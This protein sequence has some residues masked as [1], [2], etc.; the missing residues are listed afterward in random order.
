MHLSNLHPLHS[1]PFPFIPSSLIQKL[2]HLVPEQVVAGIL[3]APSPSFLSL[4]C[5]LLVLLIAF[6]PCLPVSLFPSCSCFHTKEHLNNQVLPSLS[7]SHSHWSDAPTALT[8]LYLLPSHLS[9][10]YPKLLA[11]HTASMLPFFT[12]LRYCTGC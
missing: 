7:L 12:S 5:W 6:L 4:A 3:R 9:C 1:H 10:S 11:R 8:L 2:Y